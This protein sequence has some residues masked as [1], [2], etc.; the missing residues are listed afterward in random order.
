MSNKRLFS[1]LAVT[2]LLCGS[3]GISHAATK[4][5]KKCEIAAGKNLARVY[6]AIPTC[7]SKC[8]KAGGD[9]LNCSAPTGSGLAGCFQKE[10]S[11]AAAR[12][13]KKCSK[14]CSSPGCYSGSWC[15]GQVAAETIVTS[16]A[17]GAN[18]SVAPL[19]CNTDPDLSSA[20]AKCRT[21]WVAALGVYEGRVARCLVKC[22]KTEFK[23]NLLFGTCT[24]N[25]V[26][27]TTSDAK[28][29]QCIAKALGKLAAVCTESCGDVPDCS[30]AWPECAFTTGTATAT[31]SANDT[32]VFC[33]LP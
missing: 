20:E 2:L 5:Q 25:T 1:M 23:K 22:H 18:T 24:L 13:V 4:E 11:K 3:G 30:P 29:N 32:A 14:A 16:Y 19:L 15:L 17:V 31:L 27:Y 8:L 21:K 12:I 9:P 6:K 28:T 7:Q 26:S 33:V 10:V